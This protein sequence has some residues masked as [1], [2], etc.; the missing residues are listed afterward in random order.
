[1]GTKALLKSIGLV[2]LSH[3]GIS[4]AMELEIDC[5]CHYLRAHWDGGKVE[6]VGSSSVLEKIQVKPRKAILQQ[7]EV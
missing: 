3:L 2:F 7:A 4:V 5:I 6:V 1:M